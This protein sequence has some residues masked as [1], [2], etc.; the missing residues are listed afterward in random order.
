[1][2]GIK[3]ERGKGRKRNMERERANTSFQLL[4]SMIWIEWTSQDILITCKQ[5]SK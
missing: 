4:I 3:S 1:M 5:M 2:R